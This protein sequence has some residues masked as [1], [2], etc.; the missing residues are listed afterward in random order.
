MKKCHDR[1]ELVWS[2]LPHCP[3]TGE[4]EGSKSLRDVLYHVTDCCSRIPELRQS[5]Q[6]PSSC[7]N[8]FGP[9]EVFYWVSSILLFKKASIFMSYVGYLTRYFWMPPKIVF[10]TKVSPRES[11]SIKNCV[12]VY[13][14]FKLIT[15][16]SYIST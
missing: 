14:S 5:G 11:R 4:S 7:H 2:F 3:Q 15:L 10:T 13:L 6:V 9:G 1:T 12:D 16:H 8:C